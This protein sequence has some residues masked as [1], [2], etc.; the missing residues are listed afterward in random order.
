[1]LAKINKILTP[2]RRKAIYGVVAA[3]VAALIAFD[4]ITADEL[5][6]TLG[7]IV[8]VLGGCSSLMA[9]F[10]VSPGPNDPPQ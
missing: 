10:N 2:G 3:A 6:G 4:V 1:M 8:M 9:F 5:S 7:A